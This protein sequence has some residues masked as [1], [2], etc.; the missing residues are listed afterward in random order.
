LPGGISMRYSTAIANGQVLLSLFL[1]LRRWGRGEK[2]IPVITL[3]PGAG[4][5]IKEFLAEKGSQG[6][7]RVDLLSTGCCDVSLGLSV[8]RIRKADLIEEVD[9]LQFSMG[10]ETYQLVG[11]VTI[12][13]VDEREKRG[14]V[15]TS[16]KPVSEWAGFG[17]CSIRCL[18]AAGGKT[19][20]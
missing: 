16:S 17:V 5:A 13:S 19:S 7:I 10:P 15:L 1:S 11:E 8:D 18:S 4:Q 6:P 20:G 12:S 9:G 2:A 3:E 14:F